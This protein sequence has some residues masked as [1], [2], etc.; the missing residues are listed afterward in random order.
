MSRRPR[1]SD[2]KACAKAQQRIRELEHEVERLTRKVARE[3]KHRGR[4]PE[5]PDDDEPAA[6]PSLVPRKD[7]CPKCGGA[8]KDFATPNGTFVVC[9]NFRLC[10]WRSKR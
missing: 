2:C 1:E 3:R 4:E 5:A 10:K 7:I 8:V 9:E 6:A